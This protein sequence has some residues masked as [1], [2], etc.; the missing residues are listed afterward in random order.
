MKGTEMS[1][2]MPPPPMRPA[3]ANS[4][5]SDLA[6]AAIVCG[7]IGLC[8]PGVAV[9]GLLLGIVAMIKASPDR[10]GL[11]K[12]GTIISACAMVLNIVMLVL[13]LRS[14]FLV[15]QDRVS[16]VQEL[17]NLRQIA[18]ANYAFAMDNDNRSPNH[19]ADLIEY[20]AGPNG[21]INSDPDLPVFFVS[22]DDP[23]L[24]PLT[25]DNPT[26]TEPYQFGSFIFIPL[27]GIKI[28][29]LPDTSEIIIAYSAQPR[30]VGGRFRGIAF[31][32][33]HAI[34]VSE[35]EFQAYLARHKEIVPPDMPRTWLP[36]TP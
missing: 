22:G 35:E 5:S 20:L 4:A 26:P 34:I 31:L 8:I 15:S 9:I 19:A 30:E 36:V 16:R 27:G 23:T 33:G 17:S 3:T 21:D 1:Q 11:P 13:I 28:D 14:V 32:D 10:K 12:I 6:I 7:A 2:A 18:T 25:I 24:N 29:T